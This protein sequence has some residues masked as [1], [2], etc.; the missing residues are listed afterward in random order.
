MEQDICYMCMQ[1]EGQL[2][3]EFAEPMCE[4]K[5]SIKIHFYCLA[6][7]IAKG[8]KQCGACKNEFLVSRNQK[9]LSIWP[10]GQDIMKIAEVST[11]CSCCGVQ[12]GRS[13]IRKIETLQLIKLTNITDGKRNGIQENWNTTKKG[14]YYLESSIY[15]KDNKLDGAYKKYYPNGVIDTD[16]N[17]INN[18]K[19]GSYVRKYENDKY[20]QITT[21][22]H[23]LING[24]FKSFYPNGS[25][26]IEC[27]YVM[28]KLHGH[29]MKWRTDG[30]IHTNSH[31]DNGKICVTT[32]T[33]V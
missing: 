4:C 6:Q 5:G 19:H 2:G 1:H 3:E 33:L 11:F 15:Y 20:M 10:C 21:Y 29:Y 12:N 24:S 18:Q 23:G 9:A 16:A 7:M 27:T 8:I 32:D 28:G 22:E 31:Y 30:S 25:R 13:E 26:D 14:K 17:Y